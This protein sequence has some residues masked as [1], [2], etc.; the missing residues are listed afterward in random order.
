M[1]EQAPASPHPLSIEDTFLYTITC[2]HNNKH[3]WRLPTHAE[4]A[5][6]ALTNCWRNIDSD[7]NNDWA[8][9]RWDNWRTQYVCIPVRN[10]L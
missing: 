9:T 6:Y 5:Y 3:D 10:K 4:V 1:I 7:D 8:K 2:S